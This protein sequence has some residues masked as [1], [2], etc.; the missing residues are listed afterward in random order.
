MPWLPSGVRGASNTA[1]A[2]EKARRYSRGPDANGFRVGSR[3]C[4]PASRKVR[5]PVSRKPCTRRDG[6]AVA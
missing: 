6:C 4:R 5:V 2:A 3:E 1:N